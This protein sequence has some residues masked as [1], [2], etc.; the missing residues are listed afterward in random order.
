[1]LRNGDDERHLGLN[2][3]FDGAGGLVSGDIDGRGVGPQKPNS[4]PHSW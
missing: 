3:F 1:M 4:F 2:G